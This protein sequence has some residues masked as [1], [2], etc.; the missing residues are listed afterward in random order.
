MGTPMTYDQLRDHLDQIYSDPS[1]RLDVRLIEKLQAELFASTDPKVSAAL[2]VQISNLLPT[3]QEDPTPLTNL[4]TKAATYLNYS[5]IRSIEPPLDILAGIKAPSHPVNLLALSLLRK[6]SESVSD[7]AVVAGDSALVTSLVEIW[8]TST[9]TAVAEAA[10][11]VLWCLLRIDHPNQPWRNGNMESSNSGGLGLMWRRLFGDRNVYS[12]L[13]SICCLDND[14]QPGQPSKREKSVAQGRL[15]DFVTRVGS[16]DWQAVTASHFP[17]VELGFKCKN[18]LDF[19]A[20]QMVDTEDVLLHMTL[21][22]FLEDLLK[23][24]APGFQ[25]RCSTAQVSHPMFSSPS[26]DFLVSSGLHHRIMKYFVEPSTLDP[27]EAAYLS[28]PIMAYVSQYAQL[29]PNHLLQN[30]QSFLDKILTRTLQSFDMPSVQWAHGAVPSGELNILASLPRVMLLEAGKRSLN[31]LFSIPSKP[32]HKDTLGAL[33]RIFHGP[34]GRKVDSDA[35]QQEDLSHNPTSSR[36]EAA[37]ARTLYFQYLNQ[38]TAIWNNV[39]AAAETVAMTDTALAAI[40]F[41]KAVATAN[42]D[43]IKQGSTSE[44]ITTARFAIPTEDEVERLGPASQGNLPLHGAWALLVPPALTVVL[45]YLFKDPQTHANFVAGGR[46]DT[47]SA[48]WRIATAKYDALVA[49]ESSIERIGGSTN[50]VEDV[51]R[52]MKRRVAQGPWGNTSQ[53]GSRVDALEL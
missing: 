31:P 18:L 23:I 13:F 27:A 20:C 45:P 37:A 38:H 32:L 2:L 30:Q 43:V 36:A 44:G 12:L 46:G 42:W 34:L 39:V 8:L 17:D 14:G 29:Y 4:A 28:G 35:E 9:T 26:L 24:G 3:I 41:I 22:H 21:I 51:I 52:T 49:L 5:Q 33:G 7:A 48:V 47:E 40:A 50:G 16:L 19:A 25:Q 15:M 10:F 1:T 11:D 6:A 53:I